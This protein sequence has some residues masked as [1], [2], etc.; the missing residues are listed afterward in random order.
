MIYDHEELEEKYMGIMRDIDE[1]LLEFDSN[2]EHITPEHV[3][4]LNKALDILVEVRKDHE[5]K[6]DKWAEENA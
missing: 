5:N 4:S 1:V 3:E 2:H 6:L